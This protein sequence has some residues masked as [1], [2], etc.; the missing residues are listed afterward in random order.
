MAMVWPSMDLSLPALGGMFAFKLPVD[1][2][3]RAVTD[4]QAAE[5]TGCMA[6]VRVEGYIVGHIQRQHHERCPSP[7]Q[8]AVQCMHI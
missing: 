1:V 7:P 6:G 2:R 3:G 4:A 5:E 8:A